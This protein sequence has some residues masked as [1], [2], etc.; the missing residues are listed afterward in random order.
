MKWLRTQFLIAFIFTII[1]LVYVPSASAGGNTESNVTLP[2]A[3]KSAK[4]RILETGT[5]ILQNKSPL[6]ALNIYVDGFHFHNGDMNRQIE[7][8]HFCSAVNEDFNQCVIYNGNDQNALL[9]GIEYIIS[10]KL[11]QSLPEDEKKLWHSHVYEVKS[12]ELIAPSVPEA[13]EHEFMK[14]LASTYGKTWHTWNA[15]LPN[16][17]LPLGHPSLM[18]GFTAD[19]QIKPT[20]V[21]ARDQ[22]FNISTEA[23]KQNRA[24]IPAPSIQP[25]A[26]AWETG[27][28]VQL[29]LVS[30]SGD[31]K[32]TA[33]LEGSGTQ[34]N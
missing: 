15:E 10:E 16:L 9:M 5:A 25:G 18:M 6:D 14:K 31:L 29:Q 20:I 27:A 26:D 33:S 3:E 1:L 21:S 17:T 32:Q 34:G 2:G 24:D 19:G 30:L 8:H 23:K 7:A 11:F 22:R 28:T 12:G 4:T 13:A